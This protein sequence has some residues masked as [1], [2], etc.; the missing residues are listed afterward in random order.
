MKPISEFEQ[1][2]LLALARLDSDA[3]GMT[4]GKD[5]EARTGRVAS[6]AAVYST[7]G[8]L[9]KAG[10][11]SSWISPPTRQRGGRAT[12]HFAI[13]AAGI[14]ALE[15]SRE[16]MGRMWEGLDFSRDLETR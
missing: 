9:E 7:L 2:V 11:V 14:R 3:Y 13:E 12:K 15:Q 1:L 5:I 8:R 4:V 6:L 16:A 10:L